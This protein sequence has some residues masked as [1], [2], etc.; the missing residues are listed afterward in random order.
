MFFFEAVY[1][2]HVFNVWGNVVPT[3]GAIHFNTEFP[4]IERVSYCVDIGRGSCVMFMDAG[5]E[6]EVVAKIQWKEII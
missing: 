2:S 4:D 1:T 6:W 3:F 5:I